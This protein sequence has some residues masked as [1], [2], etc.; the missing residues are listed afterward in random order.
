MS[1]DKGSRTWHKWSFGC[2]GNNR[3][4]YK[5]TPVEISFGTL[6]T[7]CGANWVNEMSDII[8]SYFTKTQY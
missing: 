8:L 1:P 4:H 5:I 2:L 6:S 3:C 7:F